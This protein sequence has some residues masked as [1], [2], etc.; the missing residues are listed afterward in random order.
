M[1]INLD[2]ALTATHPRVGNHHP[3]LTVEIERRN[4]PFLTSFFWNFNQKKKKKWLVFS[5]IKVRRHV[6][7]EWLP[8]SRVDI[9]WVFKN[10]R[11]S[12]WW[13]RSV[14]ECLWR[15]QESDRPSNY[16]LLKIFKYW[17][18]G[19]E[20]SSWIGLSLML[21][22]PDSS[23]ALGRKSDPE[24]H[25]RKKRWCGGAVKEHFSSWLMFIR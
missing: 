12:M 24:G 19:E 1:P 3:R 14:L 5:F 18:S 10:F 22:D 9:F 20:N 4:I 8:Y 16:G 2:Q 25:G 6:A 7:L 17:S 13:T 15:K 21:G 23:R 11:R